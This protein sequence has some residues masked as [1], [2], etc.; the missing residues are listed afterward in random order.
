M[1]PA[2]FVVAMDPP[3]VQRALLHV[4]IMVVVPLQDIVAR[5]NNSPHPGKLF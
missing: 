2:E 4:P 3:V 5:M 1:T